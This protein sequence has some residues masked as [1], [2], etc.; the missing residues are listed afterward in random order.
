MRLDPGG[1]FDYSK[2]TGFW[3]FSPSDKASDWIA[4]RL[5]E[6]PTGI[7]APSVVDYSTVM[8]SPRWHCLIIY[9]IHICRCIGA[10]TSCKLNEASYSLIKQLL[11]S[12]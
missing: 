5:A 1:A 8:S 2:L 3:M 9:N 12:T 7:V 11:S 10:K 6:G 4:D